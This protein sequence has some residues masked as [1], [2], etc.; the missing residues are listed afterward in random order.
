MICTKCGG[1]FT[2]DLINTCPVEGDGI[3]I[4][5]VAMP[6]AAA[7][8]TSNS[9]W[10]NLDTATKLVDT[11]LDIGIDVWQA[12]TKKASEAAEGVGEVVSE[13]LRAVSDVL[14]D[15][16]TVES[17]AEFVQNLGSGVIDAAGAVAEGA[18]EVIGGVAE[19]AGDILSGL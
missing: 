10:F 5:S 11:G 9:N 15:S 16:G 8:A 17:A 2:E 1:A 13:K 6:V 7:A 12:T 14:P 19:A 18:G 3:H 4:A